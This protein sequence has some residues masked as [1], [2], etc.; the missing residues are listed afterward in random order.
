[1][2]GAPLYHM[3]DPGVTSRMYDTDQE[4][5]LANYVT[6]NVSING[7]LSYVQILPNLARTRGSRS[8]GSRPASP[9]YIPR[10]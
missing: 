3:E 8:I 10:Y 7:Q 5:I 9:L 2:T 6:S 1:M 4:A